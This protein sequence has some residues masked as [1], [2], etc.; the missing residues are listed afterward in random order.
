MCR[1][2]AISN[3]KGGVGKTTTSIGIGTSLAK[4][5]KKVLLVDLD[6]QGNCTK[7]FGIEKFNK[8]ISNVLSQSSSIKRTIKKTIMPGCD[9]IPS[10][11]SLA[12]LDSSKLNNPHPESILKN[13][14]SEIEYKY[15][16]ILIDCP[17]SLGS[18]NVNA[19][20]AA[21]KVL[22]PV[23]CEFFALEGV[24]QIL[25]TISNIKEKYNPKIEILGFLISMYDPRNKLSIEISSEIRSQF[26][27]ALF[28]T[29]IP[30]NISI[31]ESQAKGI[32]T[33]LFRPNSTGAVA[34]YQ[35]AREFIER[36]KIIY[37]K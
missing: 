2:V 19:L 24:T 20:V 12:F 22:I 35:A 28:D 18:L 13:A 7:A 10:D 17:P 6:P 36:D 32:P 15:D 9:I 34:Y 4:M 8:S 26:K 29:I 1:V 37:Q 31:P 11:L 3:Q 14:L 25:A 27:E 33:I 23:Q 5:G 21:N 16:Y 30:R